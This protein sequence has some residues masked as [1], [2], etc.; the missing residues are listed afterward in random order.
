MVCLSNLVIV[1][2]PA[3]AKTIK[4][5]LG[6]DFEV[7]ASMGHV[8]DLPKSKFGV[9]VDHDFTPM[10][11]DIK[12]KED[13][14]KDL[15]KAAQ[16]SDAIFLATDP[17][18]EG[19]AISWHLAQMLG[20]DMNQPNR[21]T[22]NEI[23]KSG[24]KYGMDH[25]RMIDVKLVDAQ[26][27]R[28]VLDRIV[29]YKISP[30]LWRKV[31]KGLSAGRV[32]SVAVRIIMD[33]E[34]EI[35]AFKQQEYW[36]IDAKLAA[37][38]HAKKPF[39]AKLYA[40]D[41]KKLELTAIP[42]EKRARE[43]VE[44]LD[45]ADYIVS[46]V[47][48]GVRRK[49]PAPP[50]ITSTLQQEASRRLGYQSRRTMKVAQELYEGVE[51]EGIG[52]TGLITYMRTDSLRISDEAA[53]QA[54]IYITDTYGKEYL[55]ATRRVFKTKK[56]AQDA[57]EAI[58]PSDP[59]LT[60]DRVK[61]DL[62]AE[63]YKL[64]KL[65]WERFIASQMAN[66]LLDTVAVDIEAANCLF[67]ASGFTVKFDGFTVLYE[68]SKDTDDE[69][70]ASLP[71][72]EAG[73]VLTLK[74]LTPNQH[75]TQPP[76]RYTEASLIKTLEENGI[77]R[78]STYAPTITTILARGYVERENKSL[79]PTALGEVT[80][81]LMEEQFAKIVDV[82]FTANMEKTL[83]EV[84]EGNVDYPKMLS[85]FYD[86]FMTT[87]EQAEKNM[88][89]TRV[90]VPDEETDIVCELCGRKMVIKTGRFGKFLACPGFPECRNT[91]KIVKETGGLCPVCG[92]K[93]LAKKSKNGKGYYGCEHNPQC[94]FMTWDKPLSETCPKCGSTL[95][96]KTGRGA[97]I[98]CLKEGC[99]YARPVKPKKEADE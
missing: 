42:D 10:Y 46:N 52:A 57:H 55:P 30:F 88:D 31:R 92:G 61:K 34:E 84:E 27:A 76:A 1:E 13:L 66:A 29:G 6:K 2:S 11:V 97:L 36:S 75:F 65:I 15:K 79:K 39:P 67:K 9:D 17:D 80:T 49:S 99:D 96:Q 64:Y 43:I 5:Y 72:L 74:E 3:K 41:G 62:T 98:H 89:G 47:K 90:K 54:K 56:N 51:I 20:V 28:R 26:Q 25:P 16:K 85:G 21:V 40:I 69:N 22:F 24:V 53:E 71:P 82:T 63:Q 91:K 93:V 59:S 73:N 19:E 35:R 87:L 78:P 86:D 50:F 23:T 32:Q 38:G 83:D 8:R 95:F 58:R 60:P 37:K 70:T 45:G 94:Q 18:R 33:R 68:E 48:K 14:I 44:S 81:K 12:G 7:V 4:K 77:G